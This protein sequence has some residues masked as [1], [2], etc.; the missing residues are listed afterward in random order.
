MRNRAWEA[1]EASALTTKHV[2]HDIHIDLGG[3][4]ITGTIEGVAGGEGVRVVRVR[5]TR[6]SEVT[7][8]EVGLKGPDFVVPNRFFPV[9]G[10]APVGAS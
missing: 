9:L 3:A 5:T 10:A 6:A 8:A 4:N 2:H 1:V 7:L